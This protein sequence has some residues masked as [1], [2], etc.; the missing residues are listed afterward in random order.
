[1]CFTAIGSAA[2]AVPNVIAKKAAAKILLRSIKIPRSN[3]QFDETSNCRQQK[4]T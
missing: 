3:V 1:M 2:A 4:A